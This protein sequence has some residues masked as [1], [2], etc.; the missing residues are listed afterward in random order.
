MKILQVLHQFLPDHIGGI[1]IYTK[2][3]SKR[4]SRLENDILVF[5]GQGDVLWCPTKTEGM[6]GGVR[7]IYM[8]NKDASQKHAFSFIRTFRNHSVLALFDWVI[9]DFQ[10]DIIHF[11]H[12]L[13]LSGEMIFLAKQRGIPTVLTVHD[14]WF[15]CHRLHLLNRRGSQCIGPGNGARCSFCIG[16]V[17]QG[18]LRWLKPVLYFIPLIYR[19]RYQLKVMKAAD[20]LVIPAAFLRD[21]LLTCAGCED[22]IRYVPYGI[23]VPHPSSLPKNSSDRIRFGYLGTIKRHKGLHVLIDAFN[24]LD[25]DGATLD[26]HGDISAD[27]QYYRKLMERCQ[28]DSVN[29]RGPYDNQKIGDILKEI[30]VLVV[31]SVWRE[32]GPMVILEA[33]ASQIPVIAPNLGGMAELIRNGKNGLLF[34]HGEVESL[35]ESIRLVINDPSILLNLKPRLEEKHTINSN[36]DHLNEIYDKLG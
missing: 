26:I 35:R 18:L 20:V 17:N 28:R 21:I 6:V 4:L 33:L 13:Y 10:P 2:N 8:R 9:K 30:D 7:T 27:A 32:T 31:P 14:H 12:T 29:F 3:L 23:P 34:E 36:A 19:T 24:D 16:A 15:L 25:Q 11:H 5:T 22:K 1:E